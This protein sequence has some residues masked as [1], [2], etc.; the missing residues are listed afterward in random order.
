MTREHDFLNS[1]NSLTS[2]SAFDNLFIITEHFTHFTHPPN[3]PANHP[4]DCPVRE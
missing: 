2:Y 3:Q 1:W 4:V